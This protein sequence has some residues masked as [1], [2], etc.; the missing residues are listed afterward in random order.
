MNTG[1]ALE[2]EIEGYLNREL[3]RGQLGIDPNYAQV[4]RHKGYHSSP[5]NKPITVDV[6]L[7][8]SRSGAS[9]PYWIWIW[10]CKDYA[11]TV[12]VDDVEEFHAKLEQLGMNKIKGTIACRNGFQ[13]SAVRVARSWGIG[14]VRMLPSGSVIHLLEAKRTISMDLVLFGLMEPDTR[15]LESTFYSIGSDGN[16]LLNMEDLLQVELRGVESE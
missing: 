8:V 4:F 14:L 5:R 10:E 2:Q 13:D 7:E 9:K 3:K 11:K 1:Q 12:P 15:N 6:S 16:P